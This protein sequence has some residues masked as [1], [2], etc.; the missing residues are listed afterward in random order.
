MKRLLVLALLAAGCS[1]PAPRPPVGPTPSPAPAGG[2]T[3]KGL[4]LRVA[5]LETDPER[6]FAG[7]H[8]QTVTEGG[9]LLCSWNRDRHIHLFG[10]DAPGVYDVAFLDARGVVVELA[11]LPGDREQGVTS[12]KEARHALILPPGWAARHKLAAGDAA[13]VGAPAVAE[14]PVVAI[15]GHLVHVETS[16]LLWQRMRGLMHRP[17]MSADE[18]MLFCYRDEDFHSFWMRNTLMPLDIAH[19]RGDGTLINVCRMKTYP[20][21]AV[22]EDPRAPS[23]DRAQ[24]VL[25]VNYGWFDARKLIDKDGKPAG[26]VKMQVPP[27]ILKLAAEAD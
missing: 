4:P 25:E 13:T 1:S 7:D 3:L 20:N 17:R 21:P 22:D 11:A 8:L 27:A 9:A 16:H 15:N 10:K 12:A 26:A 6:R 14:M 19:F 5:R 23:D 2:F 24:Y 18:G